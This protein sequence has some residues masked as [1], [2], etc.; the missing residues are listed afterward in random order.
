[1]GYKSRSNFALSQN[2]TQ[3][4]WDSLFPSKP[5]KQECTCK[6]PCVKCSCK[7]ETNVEERGKHA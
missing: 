5:V 2:I 3:E 4:R 6:E 1:M 7:E